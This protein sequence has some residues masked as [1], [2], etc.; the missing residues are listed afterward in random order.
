MRLVP[1]KQRNALWRC[2]AEPGPMSRRATSPSGA[3]L[4]A[5]TLVREPRAIA[6][7]SRARFAARSTT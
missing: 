5:A 6:P 7:S 2:A 3:R 1:R 4:C